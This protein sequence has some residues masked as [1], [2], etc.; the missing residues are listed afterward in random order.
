MTLQDVDVSWWGEI[1]ETNTAL[2][3]T[4]EAAKHTAGKSAISYLIYMAIRILEM[5][6]I[7]KSTGS[8]YSG[9]HKFL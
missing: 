6:R 2:Y 4:L 8:I 7:L 5:H 1:A 3:K 9:V